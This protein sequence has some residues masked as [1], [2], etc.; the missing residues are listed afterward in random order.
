MRPETRAI[1]AAQ[2]K[3]GGEAS[4]T[5]RQRA[6]TWAQRLKRVFA[7]EIE[8]C[9]RCCGRLRV[10]ARIEEPAMIERILD[11]LHSSGTSESIDPTHASQASLDLRQVA[12]AFLD[13]MRR[14]QT[15]STCTVAQI[16]K[17]VRASASSTFVQIRGGAGQR[18]VG[19]VR[20]GL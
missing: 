5:D 19:A 2:A 4:A 11:H 9:R 20:H 1:A 14:F 7:I 17:V 13:R 10:I 18:P 15:R 6:L 12:R 8:V 3:E 16:V